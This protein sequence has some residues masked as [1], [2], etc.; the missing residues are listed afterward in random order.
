MKILAVADAYFMGAER[1]CGDLFEAECQVAP[2]PAGLMAAPEDAPAPAHGVV[3]R[4]ISGHVRLIAG[5][6]IIYPPADALADIVAQFGD[7]A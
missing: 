1:V 3:M 2:L 4:N 5:G 6:R 7:D